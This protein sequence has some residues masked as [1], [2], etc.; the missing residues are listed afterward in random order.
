V[1]RVFALYDGSVNRLP[2]WCPRT[3]RAPGTAARHQ[4][5]GLRRGRV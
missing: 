4:G 2:E 5:G 3:R 1:S